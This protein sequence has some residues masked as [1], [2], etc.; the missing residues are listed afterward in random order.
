M[1][2]IELKQIIY[3]NFKGI[4]DFT[5]HVGD[6][7]T[8][9]MG[10][11]ATGKTTLFD[12]FTW[13]LFGKN[14]SEV[15]KF[16]PKP[17]DQ[18]GKEIIGAEPMV[19]AQL[20]LDGKPVTLR[21]ELKEHWTKPRNQLE[22]KR[23]SDVTNLYVDE[24]PYKVT[25]Y[26]EFINGII[27]E[28]TF[29]ML[30][31]PFA[32]NNLDW[33]DRRKILMGLV[34][35]VTDEDVAAKMDNG[36]ELRE[37]LSDH[38]SEEQR[39]IIAAQRKKIKQDINGI[40]ARIDEA[41]R[42]IP[43]ISEDASSQ[44]ELETMLASY[45]DTE[46]KQQEA[47]QVAKSSGGKIAAYDEK[48]KINDELSSKRASFLEG[49]NMQLASIYDD[50]ATAKDKVRNLTEQ[51][52]QLTV[53]VQEV[54]SSIESLSENRDSL[55]KAYH[56]IEDT[57]FDENQ[58]TC[59]TCG[60]ELQADK[61]ENIRKHFQLERSTKLEDIKKRG[62][63]IADQ[64]KAEK[65]KLPDVRTQLETKIS[66]VDQAN[67]QLVDL[68]NE[69]D[70]RKARNGKFED[71]QIF[72]ELNQKLADLDKKITGQQF[73]NADA[74]SKAQ[75]DL[76]AVQQGIAQVQ[77]ELGKYE[78]VD[79]QNKRIEELRQKE[80]D[81]K[82]L[83]NDLDRKA[84]LLD[85]FVR[86]R[87]SMLETRINK[88]FHYVSFKLFAEQKNGEIAD[89]CEA[90]VDGVPFSTDLNNAAKINAGLD[91]INTLSKHY[92]VAAP[93]FV[94]N[95]ESVNEIIPTDSQ[96]IELIVSQEEKLTVQ[97]TKEMEVA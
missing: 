8:A 13:L 28:D 22:K 47:L 14:S 3:H 9:V 23:G 57:V 18:A 62:V 80:A 54:K 33:K 89:V 15:A 39:K 50:V 51:K 71:T 45:R 35:D 67:Q 43:K 29:K 30:T 87:V 79:A 61:Q 7:Q 64:L 42:A 52:S 77:G 11:N 85:E 56:S 19:E 70:T 96:Q 16:N 1:K 92:D 41:S 75:S 17:L 27:D 26:N 24:V 6:Q 40:P 38:T 58:L 68:E 95:A 78:Q 66:E 55:L 84:S 49:S 59:P 5:L 88:L 25:A 94:D 10:R 60:Q 12:G 46:A 81:L 93:I 20:L 69:L 36:E 37:M 53:T 91:I 44:L 63:E 82:D 31:N 65:A 97:D 48:A 86:T 73:D 83:Y 32:F 21:R 34:S 4:K 90:T 72:Q 2:K 74:I 76:D